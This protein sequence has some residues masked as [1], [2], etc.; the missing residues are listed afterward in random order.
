MNETLAIDGGKPVTE[1]LIS[2]HEPPLGLEK[3]DRAAES[4]E[5]KWVAGPGPFFEKVESQLEEEWNVPRVL[6]TTSCT[7]AMEIALLA[8]SLDE[9]DEVIVPSFTYVS[10]ALAVLRAGA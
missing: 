5:S 4:I 3:I 2:F 10:T 9:T 1:N 7:H 6:T 8:L